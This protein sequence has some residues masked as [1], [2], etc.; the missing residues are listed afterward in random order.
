MT[1]FFRFLS[2]KVRGMGHQGHNRRVTGHSPWVDQYLERCESFDRLTARR[3]MGANLKAGPD[4]MRIGGETFKRSL[5]GPNPGRFEAGTSTRPHSMEASHP[6]DDSFLVQSP[7]HRQMERVILV[8]P[9]PDSH[10]RVEADL[11]EERAKQAYVRCVIR[12]H[13]IH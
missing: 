2:R 3:L 1:V 13:Q 12:S 7:L 5:P 4:G 11:E 10:L 9:H 8:P 6:R